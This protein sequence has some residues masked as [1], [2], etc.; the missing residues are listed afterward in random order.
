[1]HDQEVNLTFTGMEAKEYQDQKVVSALGTLGLPF[2][3][4]P[5]WLTTNSAQAQET[6]SI[7]A[8]VPAMNEMLWEYLD[9]VAI[10]ADGIPMT[11]KMGRT[12]PSLEFQLF[13]LAEPTHYARKNLG[14]E[15]FPLTARGL[16]NARGVRVKIQPRKWDSWCICLSSVRESSI[17][18]LDQPAT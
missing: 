18:A 10:S 3:G 2:A 4:P 9:Q 11:V 15:A 12:D 7:T 17:C 14:A 13:F 1:M 16:L 6:R 8:R 5:K